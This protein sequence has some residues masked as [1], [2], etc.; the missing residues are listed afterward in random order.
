M[1]NDGARSS[2]LQGL[3]LGVVTSDLDLVIYSYKDSSVTCIAT[4][5]V[6]D[7]V[8]AEIGMLIIGL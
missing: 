2:S 4:T 6:K 8:P 5:S 3:M 1:L 7:L